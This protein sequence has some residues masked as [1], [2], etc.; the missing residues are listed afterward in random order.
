MSGGQVMSGINPCP[1]RISYATDGQWF[2]PILDGKLMTKIRNG[3]RV[4]RRVLSEEAAYT[5]AQNQ[6]ETEEAIA[7]RKAYE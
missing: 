5:L 7:E 6:I 1:E 3:E 2:V 4:V